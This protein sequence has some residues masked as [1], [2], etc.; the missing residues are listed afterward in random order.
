MLK[1]EDIK[2]G[3]VYRHIDTD[4]VTSWSDW[5]VVKFN[6][7]GDG[8]YVDCICLNHSSVPEEKFTGAQGKLY[9]HRLDY[10]HLIEQEEVTITLNDI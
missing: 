9:L 2:L 10:M 1:K 6:T 8:E 3:G 4:D 5:Q 7:D